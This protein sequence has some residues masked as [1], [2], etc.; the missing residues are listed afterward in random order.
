M[1]ILL[2]SIGFIILTS[3]RTTN[4][5]GTYRSNCAEI[6]FF[7][8]TVKLNNDSTFEYRFRGDLA[9]E[10]GIGTFTVSDRTLELNFVKDTTN[11]SKFN[12]T[13]TDS[14]GNVDIVAVD[15]SELLNPTPTEPLTY[16]LGTNKL[17]VTNNEGDVVKRANCYSRTRRFIFWG[18]RF[19][20]TRK[21]YLDKTE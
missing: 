10:S 20:T 5:V 8:T 18:D 12:M 2:I 1:R 13:F 4:L 9:N 19:M 15:L 6:G 17:W 3:C 14:L 16:K 21:Y 11:D 7:V